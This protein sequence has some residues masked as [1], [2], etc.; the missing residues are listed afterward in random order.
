VQGYTATQAGAALLP[1][2]LLVFLLSRWSGGLFA[3]YGPKP[4]LVIG[5][6]IAA[7]GFALF[8]RPGIGDSYW[9][10]YFPPVVILGLGM[11]ISIAPL[12]TTVMTAVDQR[13]AESLPVST[14]PFHGSPACWRSRSSDWS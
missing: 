13:H 11:A 3:R 4:P 1:F 7:L 5:P 12:T 2:I 10:A 14:M 9:T 8:A 6:L